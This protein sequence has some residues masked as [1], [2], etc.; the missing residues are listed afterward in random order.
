M[1]AGRARLSRR[2]RDRRRPADR[3]RDEQRHGMRR[4]TRRNSDPRALR[5]ARARRL[6]DRVVE[7]AV[8]AAARLE[9]R[10]SN[11]RAR[12]AL[13]RADRPRVC[14]HRPLVLSPRA[15][16]ARG[17]TRA[18]AM[19]RR[20]RR[21]SRDRRQRS[22][23]PGGR[24]WPRHSLRAP[25]APS[26]HCSTARMATGSSPSRITSGSTP[27]SVMPR[28]PRSSMRA[29]SERPPEAVASLIGDHVEELCERVDSAGSCAYAVDVTSPDVA[30][31][32]LTVTKVIAPELCA[33]DVAHRARFLG[34]PRTLRRCSGC[35]P[36]RRPTGRSRR[37]S[38]PASIPVT[39]PVPTAEF[40]S[41]VY[42]SAGVAL[43]D[44]A[45]DFHE[46]SRLYPDVAPGRLPAL[47]ELA[48][49]PELQQTVARS[50]RTH[51]QRSGV[52]LP[53]AGIGRMLLDDALTQ[54][55]SGAATAPAV[56]SAEH[57]ARCWPPPIARS[58]ACVRCL[59]EERSIRSSCTWSRWPSRPRGGVVPL[60]PVSAP[61]RALGPGGAGRS[62]RCPRRS[63]A[64]RQ[65][66]PRWS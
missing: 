5:I 42:G 13:L 25:P 8:A 14:R 1:A 10:R 52:D 58:A 49:S 46:A 18:R 56:L 45:E 41:L 4:N 47:F 61:A 65:T 64:R 19:R 12:P 57:L 33:L 48:H 62:R 29:P 50:S 24:R 34:G 37:Q 35:G 40:A 66:R 36:A 54:R 22:S 16:C 30:E 27:T 21:R 2:R 38:R 31:L 26:S 28:G 3:V 55:R 51:A 43:D 11:R 59:Q 39:Q 9:R 20:A 6:H 23:A 32:G 7:P 63:D 17:R 15:E 60:Q 44:P 53:R